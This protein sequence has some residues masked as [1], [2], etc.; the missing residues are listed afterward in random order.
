[1]GDVEK[2]LNS[3]DLGTTASQSSVVRVV[4]NACHGGFGLSHDA[5]MAYAARKGIA[6]YAWADDISTKHFGEPDDPSTYRGIL[7][8]TTVPAEQYRELEADVRANDKD[9][10]RLN[11]SGWFWSYRDVPRDDPDLVSVVE[12]MG[13]KA[14][15]R[16]AQLRIVEVPAGVSWCIEEYDG[17]EWIAE[18]HRTWS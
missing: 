18:E 15:G 1:M 7:H 2:K 13:A 10:K 11:E 4:I 5:A 17:S 6:L 14:N 16:H 9:Y 3:K 8:Y 12:E